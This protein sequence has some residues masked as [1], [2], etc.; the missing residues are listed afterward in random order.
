V[1]RCEQKLDWRGAGC[2]TIYEIELNFDITPAQSAPVTGFS[3]AAYTTPALD[4]ARWHFRI[5]EAYALEV[6][7]PIS[8]RK[9]SLLGG[10]TYRST[11]AAEPYS[12][13][14]A[15]TKAYR[16]SHTP[17]SAMLWRSQI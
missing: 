6:I 10:A 1:S 3:S 13:I 14:Y 4:P 9:F 17:A 11:L 15:E 5:G 12:Y 16:H 7:T 8:R 2:G